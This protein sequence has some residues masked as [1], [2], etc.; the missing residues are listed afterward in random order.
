M[1]SNPTLSA[2]IS[3]LALAGRRL[4]WIR[5][6]AAD[7]CGTVEMATIERRVWPSGKHIRRVRR[8]RGPHLT[9]SFARKTDAE[10][11][12]RSIEHKF[13]VGE[14]VPSS[15]A[16]K[17]TL[18]NAADRYFEVT[19]PRSEHRKNASEQTSRTAGTMAAVSA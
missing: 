16:R 4:V 12:A 3:N 17:R 1:G 10:E 7:Q 19:L 2:N 9:K 14:Y 18:G 8:D 15:E 5:L 6:P 13:D 11:W